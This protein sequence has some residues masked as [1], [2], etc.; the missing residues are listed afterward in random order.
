MTTNNEENLASHYGENFYDGQMDGSL[1]S[2]RK[3]AQFITSIYK[4]TSVVDLG[5]GRGTWLKA[6]KEICA[7]QLMGLDGDWNS[8]DKMIDQ[9]IT[10]QSVDLNQPVVLPNNQRFDLA[11][12]LEVAEHLESASAKTFVNSITQLS[13]VIIFG[14]AYTA[15]G[16]TNHI[17]EQPHTYWAKFFYE[18]NYVVYDIFRPTFWGDPDIE[19]WYQ[20]NTFLYVKQQSSLIDTLTS[21]G[22][23]PLKNIQFMDCIHP[24]LY[25]AKLAQANITID[26]VLMYVKML[27]E[28]H[29]QYATQVSQ[30]LSQNL[31]TL[32]ATK[33]GGIPTK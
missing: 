22:M 20:Q 24:H 28:Q 30:I 16:G 26:K 14:A 3:Y 4:P 6:F 18:N 8:Q 17:N 15:Q 33:N 29:P 19:F 7:Q 12:S 27:L 23:Y 9:S 11:I 13:D 5:C 1:R 10:F 25:N 2:G 31:A 21:H 32:E